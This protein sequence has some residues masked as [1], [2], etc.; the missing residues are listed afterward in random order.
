MSIQTKLRSKEKVSSRTQSQVRHVLAPQLPF[1]S[2]LSVLLVKKLKFYGLFLTL[3]RSKCPT[4]LSIE[5]VR[6][7]QKWSG[8]AGESPICWPDIS[9]AFIINAC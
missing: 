2:S 1:K 8:E 6:T 3:C 5:I 7:K 9:F 4:G